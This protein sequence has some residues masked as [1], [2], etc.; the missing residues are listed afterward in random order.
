MK[1]GL[2]PHQDKSFAGESFSEMSEKINIA[3]SLNIPKIFKKS[4]DEE[5][6]WEQ[7]TTLKESPCG[8]LEVFG[9]ETS[10]GWSVA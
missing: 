2:I 1:L 8:M 6:H 9:R 10:L 5:K 4:K 7:P 3:A